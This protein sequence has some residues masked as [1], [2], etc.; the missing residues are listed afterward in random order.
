MTRRAFRVLLFLGLIGAAS[1]AG[2]QG[3]KLER[4]RVQQLASAEAF[5][6]LTQRLAQGPIELRAAQRA[7]VSSGQGY[8]YWRPSTDHAIQQIRQDLAALK[9]S[10]PR[11]AGAADAALEALNDTMR[12][13]KR[14]EEAAQAGRIPFA[15]DLIFADGLQANLTLQRAID[16]AITAARG[17][18]EAYQRD[19]RVQ[20]LLLAAESA[21]IGLFLALMWY[22]TTPRPT[23]ADAQ[24]SQ[25]TQPVRASRPAPAGASLG[26]NA[27]DPS[28]S[29][30][31]SR[32][33]PDLPLRGPDMA[34][35]DAARVAA[36]A[37]DRMRP[38]PSAP[39]VATH[40][41][42]A[43][44]GALASSS[45][46]PN[47][48]T[49]A[50]NANANASGSAEAANAAPTTAATRETLLAAADLC[51]SL[52]RVNDATELNG[53][54][55]Q[56]ST[57]LDAAGVIVWLAAPD[58]LSLRPALS[59]GYPPEA[60]A[61]LERLDLTTDNATARAYRLV[62]PQTVNAKDSIPGAIVVPITSGAGCVGAV[63]A[64]LRHGR[65]QD[66]TTLALARIF[67][68]Q[69]ATLTGPS[70]TSP[71]Q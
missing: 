28:S 41:P 15:A 45:V 21:C 22:P 36:A 42:P 35:A 13:E 71:A 20:E 6:D 40:A 16:A 32:G 37:R 58:G 57:Q 43:A 53:L 14:I 31:A 63:A 5:D 2:Y 52:A 1:L 34:R 25:S 7:Y 23:V 29:A 27:I 70:S 50:A 49:A 62:R 60:L 51:T 3:W 56:M 8:A 54:L 55:A 65:E 19:A 33:L 10:V 17:D 44:P 26:L 38:G 46:A 9:T 11:A 12:I 68:A 24:S 64:E 47:A 66:A 48:A 61:R 4:A 39:T 30:D 18:L 69:L 59:H 67:A